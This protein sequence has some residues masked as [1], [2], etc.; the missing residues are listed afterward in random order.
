MNTNVP[1]KTCNNTIRMFFHSMVPKWSTSNEPV[2]TLWNANFMWITLQNLVPI[3]KNIQ[4]VSTIKINWLILL[5]EL[6]VIAVYF[7]N[8]KKA[9]NT[10]CKQNSEVLNV[11]VCGIYTLPLCLKGL[12]DKTTKENNRWCEMDVTA[13]GFGYNG[14]KPSG[15]FFRDFVVHKH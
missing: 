1:V 13:S 5:R 9:I 14:I 3:Q 7:A 2:R 8:H 11:K 12:T 15:S 10:L 6:F 4:Y